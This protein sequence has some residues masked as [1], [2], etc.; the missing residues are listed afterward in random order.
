MKQLNVRTLPTEQPPYNEWCEE[1]KVSSRVQEREGID[2]ANTIMAEWNHK[3]FK[4]NI[5]QSTMNEK[6]S[7]SLTLFIIGALA[8]IISLASCKTG[9]GCHGNQSWEK[10]VKRNNKFN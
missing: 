3:Q 1:F 8:I 10:M 9:Y 6:I 4:N 7:H 5:K 2:R